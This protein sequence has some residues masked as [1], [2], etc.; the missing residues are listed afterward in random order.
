MVE[1][2]QV[3]IPEKDKVLQILQNELE[4]FQLTVS[5]KVYGRDELAKAVKE[6]SDLGVKVG[7]MLRARQNAFTVLGRQPQ[8]FRWTLEKGGDTFARDRLLQEVKTLGELGVKIV[9]LMP[10][11][12]NSPREKNLLGK[13]YLC[14]VCL[15]EFLCLKAGDGITQCCGQDTI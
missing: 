8:E 1:S 7:E 12:L 10:H 3:K 6:E 4:S 15:C 5:G 2:A 11:G 9:G 14:L 13:R